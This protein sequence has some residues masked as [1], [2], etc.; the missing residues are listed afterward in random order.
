MFDYP[1]GW[2]QLFWAIL[3]AILRA[4]PFQA[5]W[6][7]RGGTSTHVL[8]SCIPGDKQNRTDMFD[9][10]LHFSWFDH[11]QWKKQ[12]VNSTQ[13]RMFTLPFYPDIKFLPFMSFFA[14]QTTPTLFLRPFIKKFTR[15]SVS[16]P[17]ISCLFHLHAFFLIIKLQIC[18]HHNIDDT[19]RHHLRREHE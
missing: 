7:A 2:A 18:Y 16:I 5:N 9:E 1:Y 17:F 19:H 3:R 8:Q 15:A 10:Q 13:N 14:A 12:E 11:S 6:L 4:I